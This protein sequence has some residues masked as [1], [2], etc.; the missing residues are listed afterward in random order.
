MLSSTSCLSACVGVGLVS[1]RRA[2]ATA[3]RTADSCACDCCTCAILRAERARHENRCERSN[4]ERREA[5]RVAGRGLSASDTNDCSA[6][7]ALFQSEQHAS[8]LL[9]AL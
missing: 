8:D 2:S 5:R 6:M 1:S 7:R 9:A 3:E 4:Y